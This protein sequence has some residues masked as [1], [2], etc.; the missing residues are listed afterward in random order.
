MSSMRDILIP[1]VLL[2]VSLQ[3]VH[4]YLINEHL[5]RL[6]FADLEISTLYRTLRHLEQTGL[7]T[8]AWEPGADGPARR[9][10]ELTDVG[11]TWLASWAVG[12]AA[13][14]GL[15]DRFFGLYVPTTH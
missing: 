3:R 9:V 13:Y 6:G 2:A 5:S 12:L 10:Y 8:S 7:L 11:R 14:R 1:H 4:G 15:I